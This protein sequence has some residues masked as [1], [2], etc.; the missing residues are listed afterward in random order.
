MVSIVGVSEKVR[1]GLSPRRRQPEPGLAR[2]PGRFEYAV[3]VEGQ[4]PGNGAISG[5]HD[6]NG[7]SLLAESLVSHHRETSPKDKKSPV[8]RICVVVNL[9][10]FSPR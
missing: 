2:G 10:I 8:E 5:G 1:N 4:Q 6:R 3:S 7:V 9:S